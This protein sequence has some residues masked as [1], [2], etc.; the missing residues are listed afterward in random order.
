MQILVCIRLAFQKLYL[1]PSFDQ[2]WVFSYCEKQI[3]MSFF[4]HLFTYVNLHQYTSSL[5][6]FLYLCNNFE[7]QFIFPLFTAK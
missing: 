3:D 7:F 5:D 6:C 2:F 1:F 4:M